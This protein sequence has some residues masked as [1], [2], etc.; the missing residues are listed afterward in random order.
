[1]VALGMN[2]LVT[3]EHSFALTLREPWGSVIAKRTIFGS[4]AAAADAM[5]RPSAN[6]AL[7]E[8]M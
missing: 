3:G 5:A 4:A 6:T 1:M 8:F 7:R 2:L